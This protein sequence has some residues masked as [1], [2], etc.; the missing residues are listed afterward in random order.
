MKNYE[1]G[2]V[3]KNDKYG[4]YEILE[5]KREK[6][7]VKFLVTGGVYDFH[8]SVVSQNRVKDYMMPTFYDVGY[9]ERPTKNIRDPISNKGLFIWAGMLKRCYNNDLVARPNYEGCRASEKWKSYYNFYLW[10]KVQ[11]DKGF[12]Q[13]G[14]Q[15]DKDLLVIGNK[16]YSED[17]CVFSPFQLNSL[18]QVKVRSEGNYLPGVNFDKSR[19]KFKSEV[20]FK[21]KRYYGVRRE[22]ELEAFLDYK[23]VKEQ[24][25]REEG[26]KWKGL[27]PDRAV[28]S[29]MNYSLDWILEEY[30]AESQES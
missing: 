10:Y 6:V 8:P 7:T 2:M 21:G 27:L 17:T 30:L 23:T 13:P 9:L 11:V 4:Y 18:L 5:S 29:L 26:A 1:V 19:S 3:I 14:Y 16:L 12:Y 20:N 22:T 15:L 25:V 24:L 28:D